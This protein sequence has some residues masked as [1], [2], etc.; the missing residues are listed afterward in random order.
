MRKTS[1]GAG[2]AH[3][4]AAQATGP[5][6]I[7]RATPSISFNSNGTQATCTINV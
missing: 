6:K 2:D 4:V 5:M 3:G 1:F 7:P